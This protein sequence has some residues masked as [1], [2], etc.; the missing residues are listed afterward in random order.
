[1]E[2]RE[3]PGQIR[4]GPIVSDIPATTGYN[5]RTASL[6][7][8]IDLITG[9]PVDPLKLPL[10]L[11][12]NEWTRPKCLC[13]IRTSQDRR[14]ALVKPQRTD[15]FACGSMC[16]VC[17]ESECPYFRAKFLMLPPLRSPAHPGRP[18]VNL[19]KFVPS[20]TMELLHIHRIHLIAHGK[21]TLSAFRKRDRHSLLIYRTRRSNGRINEDQG[22]HRSHSLVESHRF[23]PRATQT[24]VFVPKHAVEVLKCRGGLDRFGVVQPRG[25]LEVEVREPF[26]PLRWL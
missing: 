7:S 16:L 14:T 13:S 8:P 17:P 3:T 21:G 9:S 24:T 18:T 12:A 1:M 20:R 6:D 22:P 2:G 5:S 19:S 4:A 10:Y 25:Y 23:G 15:S 26:C 11:R